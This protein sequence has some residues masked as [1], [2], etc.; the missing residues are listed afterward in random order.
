MVPSKPSVRSSRRGVL[1]LLLA[2]L[3]AAAGAV[4]YLSRPVAPKEPPG[5]SP[6]A[7]AYV[8][9]LGLSD[10]E[11]KAAESY[12]R[13]RLVEILGNITNKGDRVLRLV[14]INCVFYDP[15][16]QVVLRERVPI[17]RRSGAGLKPSETRK[18]RLPFD[19][20]PASWN[21]VMPQLVIAHIEFEQ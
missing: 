12:M 19:A 7:R 16:G 21:Q 20:V 8:G 1:L 11:M 3:L 18:F 14:E 5:L 2:C 9:S 4:Y 17:V 13:S 10:V 15:Y 6:E